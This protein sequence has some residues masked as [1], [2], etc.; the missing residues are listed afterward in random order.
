MSERPRVELLDADSASG[1][2]DLLHQFLEQTIEA[3]D[4]KAEAARALRGKVVVRAAEDEDIAVKILFE[5]Q[6]IELRDV[7]AQRDSSPGIQGDFLSVAHVTSGEESPLALVLSRRLR[8]SF[9][10][11]QIPFLVRVLLLMRV[12]DGR[13][14]RS[15]WLVVAPLL[16]LV[17]ALL[18][19]FMTR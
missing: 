5:G 4:E 18:L 8:V 9:G 14:R 19:Y 3:S 10:L 13:A 6:R 17:L 12:D 16:L 15:P 1:L 2:A 11:L 7:G